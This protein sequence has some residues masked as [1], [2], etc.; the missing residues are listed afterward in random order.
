MGRPHAFAAGLIAAL[1]L[2]TQASATESPVT[3]A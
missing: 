1:V 3:L 2:A